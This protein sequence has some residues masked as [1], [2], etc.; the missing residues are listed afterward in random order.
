MF[1]VWLGP[2]AGM[3]SSGLCSGNRPT[4]SQPLAWPAAS[5]LA[6]KAPGM[7][8][9]S[10]GDFQCRYKLLELMGETPTGLWFGGEAAKNN[11]P[12]AVKI[13]HGSAGQQEAFLLKAASHPHITRIIDAWLS[14]WLSN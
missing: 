8:T 14:P 4:A 9:G 1:P 13:C 7:A 2:L 11:E 6:Q 10:L 5:A 12:V 3:V